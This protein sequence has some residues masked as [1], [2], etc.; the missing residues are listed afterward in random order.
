MNVSV[1][2][3]GNKKKLF[4]NTSNLILFESGAQLCLSLYTTTVFVLPYG[5]A[6]P[7][8]MFVSQDVDY[9]LDELRGCHMVAVLGRTD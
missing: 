8:S 7:G 6:A 1:R 5:R 9:L 4:Y 2:E 3:G